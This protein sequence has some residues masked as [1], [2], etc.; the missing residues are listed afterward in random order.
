[1]VQQSRGGVLVREGRERSSEKMSERI[2]YGATVQEIELV[3]D[4]RLHY[5]RL[6]GTGP[7]EGWIS[8]YIDQTDIID[9]KTTRR[10]MLAERA[11]IPEAEPD[12]KEKPVLDTPSPQNIEKGE[13]R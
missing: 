3:N 7:D 1:M 6:T 5:R 8:I 13:D 12:V 11:R 4:E 2:S 10:K 9:G